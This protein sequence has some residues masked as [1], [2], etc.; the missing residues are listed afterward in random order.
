[1]KNLD[2]LEQFEGQNTTTE[3]MARQVFEGM[4]SG[5][6]SRGRLGRVCQEYARPES[7]AV[8][9]PHCLGQ[10]SCT[11]LTA[12]PAFVLLFPGNPDQNTGGY[13][14]VRRLAGAISDS[15]VH[16]EVIGLAGDFPRPDRRALIEMDNY[17]ERCPSSAVV[18]LDGL[19]MSAMPEVV[20]TA[21]PA[22]PSGCLDSSPTRR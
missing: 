10:F 1:M 6:Q 5:D 11:A 13:R 17:L 18:V 3:F 19:A 7:H 20:C 21:R 9:I 14:Y 15:G 22:P 8:G 12:A 16:A 4:S 2:E